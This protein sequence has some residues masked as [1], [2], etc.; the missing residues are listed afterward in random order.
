MREA[1]RKEENPDEK[2]GNYRSLS[3]ASGE[4]SN[5][6]AASNERPESNLNL[7]PVAPPSSYQQDNSFNIPIREPYHSPFDQQNLSQA[8]PSN[9]NQSVQD[10]LDKL[11]RVQEEI[12]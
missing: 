1:F 8:S 6:R 7:Q 4:K 2:E 11:R 10:Q 5:Q 9:Y 3:Q 12:D